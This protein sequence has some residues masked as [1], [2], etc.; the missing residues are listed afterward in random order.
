[1]QAYDQNDALAQMV[2]NQALRA[3]ATLLMNLVYVTN[4]KAIVLGGGVM[5]GDWFITHLRPLLQ[6]EAMRFVE[7]DVQVTTLDPNLIALIG[8][9]M[10]A[11]KQL[12]GGLL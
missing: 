11:F 1:M 5:N 6:A 10:A 4:P 3:T 8:A 9:G 7:A 2:L 12:E